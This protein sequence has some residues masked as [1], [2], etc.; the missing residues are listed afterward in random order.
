MKLH[1]NMKML[2]DEQQLFNVEAQGHD[3]KSLGYRCDIAGM[4]QLRIA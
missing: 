4:I 2:Y 3:S 1:C